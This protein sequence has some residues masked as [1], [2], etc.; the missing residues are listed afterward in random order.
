M[1]YA[2]PRICPGKWDAQTPLRFWDTNGSRNLGKMT[3][4]YNNN[5]KRTCGI[6]DFAVPVDHR[7][8][9]KES[10]KKEKYL[11]LARVLKNCETWKGYWNMKVI[12]TIIPIVIGALGTVNKGLIQGLLDLDRKRT[13]GNYRNYCI[14]DIKQNTEKS[15]GDLRRLAVHQ[16]SMKDH[17]LMR[18]W[19]SLKE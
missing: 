10:E 12:K 11:D 16:T 5:K 6:V 4:P 15:P 14:T 13:S 19:K 2:Q 17:Q 3:R 7:V 9:W 18:M 1:I 8:K